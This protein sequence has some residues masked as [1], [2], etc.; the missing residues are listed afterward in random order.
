MQGGIIDKDMPVRRPTG[1][2][3]PSCWPTRIGYRVRARREK[4]RVCKKWPG[5]DVEW[6]PTATHPRPS[7]AQAGASRRTSAPRSE[8]LGSKSSCRAPPGED[9]PEQGGGPGTQQNP[10]ST[11]RSNRPHDHHGPE[12]RSSQVPTV[13]IAGFQAAGRTRSAPRSP[14]E[15]TGLGVPR[16]AS[17]AWPSRASRDFRGPLTHGLRR[18]WQLHLRCRRAARLPNRTTT[19]S[20]RARHGQI[21]IVTNRSHQRDGRPCSMPSAIPFAAERGPMT[22]P[23][24][25]APTRDLPPQ[26]G[27]FGVGG[28][29]E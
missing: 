13:R 22:G 21:T 12:A 15:A 23:R 1:L 18:P 24:P 2:A 26:R 19:M 8:Q 5:S 10:C 11:A 17:S 9:R 20:T 4:L 6:A 3:V 27:N 7:P 25:A 14:C 28:L 29:R 16:R